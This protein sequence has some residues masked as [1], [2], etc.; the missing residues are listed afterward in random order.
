MPPRDTGMAWW[1]WVVDICFYADIVMNF[2]TGFERG[3]EVV[4]EKREIV[5]NY[6]AGWFWVDFI[7]TVEWDLI[8]TATMDGSG[9]PPP[10]VS[11]FR[12][13]KVA[14][15]LRASR[16]I[17]RLTQ[18]WTLHTGFID[19][20]TF[21]IYVLICAHILACSFWL[22]P[23]VFNEPSVHPGLLVT[24][25]ELMDTQ[26][27]L[28]SW[29][30]PFEYDIE[31]TDASWSE[32]SLN[33]YIQGTQD[34]VSTYDCLSDA[35][36]GCEGSG[37]CSGVVLDSA[38]VYTIWQGVTNTSAG[39]TAW[40][41]TPSHAK[42]IDKAANPQSKWIQSLYW[43]LTTMTTIGYGDRLPQTTPEFIFC[44]LCEIIG[45][46][47]FALLLT[48]INNLNDVM[49]KQQNERNDIKNEVVGFISHNGLGDELIDNAL[50]F[51]N[52]TA[53][54]ISSL[55]FDGDSEPWTD[56][57]PPLLKEIKMGLF[58]EPLKRVKFLGW[59]LDDQKEKSKVKMMFEKTDTDG[60]G[61]LDKNE[62][63]AL[64][65]EL[66]LDLTE[67]QME[68]SILEMD[69]HKKGD[70]GFV[71]FESW[72]FHKKNNRPRSPP[73]PLIFVQE[74]AY[75]MK[76]KPAS[77]LD[78][79][80]EEGSYGNIFNIILTGGVDIIDCRHG[81]KSARRAVCSIDSNNIEPVWGISTA[82]PEEMRLSIMRD[83]VHWK[84]I[85]RQTV[86]EKS[87]FCDIG[88]IEREALIE[89][90]THYWDRIESEDGVEE[91]QGF[92]VRRWLRSPFQLPAIALCSCAEKC[93]HLLGF[94]E[95]GPVLLR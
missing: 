54:S 92:T 3:Y 4:M 49:S 41:F 9:S 52:F 6:M 83:T 8:I 57:S 71:A 18:S 23:A 51:L 10:I 46:S 53:A 95:H 26:A 42:C 45:M 77:P 21:F 56:I 79:L 50:Y 34:G 61:A 69:P 67:E 64:V 1:E 11:L 38:G 86:E 17:N 15:L 88:Y 84:V 22:F 72:W 70:I 80:T 65:K 20:I 85:A 90:L 94:H 27:S 12:L 31:M 87:G 16:L 43:S 78:V 14:R 40:M 60:G 74:L 35:L 59:S 24:D 68:I 55:A 89:T 2:W 66:K 81:V 48:Q 75:R 13:I 76:V 30:L 36:A 33:T 32:P 19:A 37:S 5:K 47:F 62:I 7:A 58:T 63:M 73:A 39:D 91:H 93:L 25:G 82:L 28:M 44:M 29:R